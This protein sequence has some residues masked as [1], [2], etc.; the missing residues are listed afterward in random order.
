MNSTTFN[1]IALKAL[2]QTDEKLAVQVIS[3]P[4]LDGKELSAILD[5]QFLD[6]IN[7]TNEH[8]QLSN[9]VLMAG[10]HNRLIQINNEQIK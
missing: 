8:L 3:N 7:N 4:N 2:E 5:K 10:L 6:K 1:T 9:T